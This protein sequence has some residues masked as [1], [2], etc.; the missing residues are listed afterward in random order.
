MH[1]LDTS[2]RQKPQQAIRGREHIISKVDLD[3]EVSGHEQL[4]TTL[5]G[6]NL[7]PSHPLI[8]LTVLQAWESTQTHD[9]ASGSYGYLY[10]MLILQALSR[11][12]FRAPEIDVSMTFLAR[13]A[14][15]MFVDDRDDLTDAT[16]RQ[17][18][19]EYFEY[20]RTRLPDDLFDKL[21]T[22]RILTQTG[23]GGGDA[24]EA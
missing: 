21:N 13:V 5:L 24:P 2:I 11:V 19:I 12:G 6:R 14:H 7:L 9:I 3:H 23:S 4:I 20:Y 15:R 22:A 17:L 10:E 16:L 1:E 18:S 8:I